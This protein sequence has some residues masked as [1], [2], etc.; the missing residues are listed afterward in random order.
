MRKSR[1][2]TTSYEGRENQGDGH[3]G[4]RRGRDRSPNNHLVVN[5]E[6]SRSVRHKEAFMWDATRISS[7]KFKINCELMSNGPYLSVS[8]VLPC[9]DVFDLHSRSEPVPFCRVSPS[10][11]P[12]SSNSPSNY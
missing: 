1:R 8:S 9:K 11:D 6:M 2:I 3:C 12:A 5:R 7:Q 4:R 10:C